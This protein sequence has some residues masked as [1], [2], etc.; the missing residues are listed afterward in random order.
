MLNSLRR[1]VEEP[2]C[3]HPL[4]ITIWRAVPFDDGVDGEAGYYSEDNIEEE[5]EDGGGDE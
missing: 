5:H 4:G 3:R 2:W 1:R